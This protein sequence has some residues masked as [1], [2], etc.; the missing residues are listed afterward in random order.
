VTL[1]SR[2][3]SL[4]W[5]AARSVRVCVAAACPDLSRV[6]REFRGG[7][8][9]PS[10]GALGFSG[11]PLLALCATSGSPVCNT[12]RHSVCKKTTGRAGASLRSRTTFGGSS[13][14]SSA[15]AP[16]CCKVSRMNTCA[17]RVGGYPG[18]R[19]PDRWAD[20]VRKRLVPETQPPETP[21]R[22]MI[23]ANLCG[24][25]QQARCSIRS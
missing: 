7:S 4:A 1:T 19:D 14:Q 8:E 10:G 9:S 24:V 12:T 21:K 6:S 3:P 16:S 2:T 20:S 17:K 22:R 13:I 18:P 15:V 11:A 5:R 23:Q 25:R